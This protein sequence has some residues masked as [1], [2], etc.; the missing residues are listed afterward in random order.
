M[1]MKPLVWVGSC[2]RDLTEMSGELQS[3]FGYALWV[4]Q[5]GGKH[6]NAKP[7]QGFGGAGVLEVV[8]SLD[9]DAFRAVYTVKFEEAVYVLHVFQKKSTRGIETSKS[10]VEKIKA[11]LREAEEEHRTWRK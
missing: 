3:K 10:D 11:R 6:R 9:G 7:L 5:L 2:Y 8:E 4:A 1:R